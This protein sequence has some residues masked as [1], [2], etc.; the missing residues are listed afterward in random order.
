[1]AVHKEIRKISQSFHY[2]MRG[3]ALCLRHERNFRIHF[4]TAI[5]VTLFALMARLER[6]H[7]VI[8]L[9]CYAMMMS[10][11]L[12]NTAIERLCDKQAD[13]YNGLVRDA[14][15]IAAAAVFVCALFC[16]LIGAFIF[17]QKNALDN[18]LHYITKHTF[19]FLGVVATTP[20]AVLFIF[21]GFWRKK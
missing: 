9:I 1:M 7:Y 18:I 3:I 10:A 21:G 11:E 16:V 12:I 6:I 20:I 5:Y 19:T 8:L 13:G 4:C 15:D 17:L 2:A 14:K